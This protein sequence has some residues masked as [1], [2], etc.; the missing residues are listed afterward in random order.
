MANI[1]KKKDYKKIYISFDFGMKYDSGMLFVTF[2]QRQIFG[3]Q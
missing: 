3:T 1:T 2:A